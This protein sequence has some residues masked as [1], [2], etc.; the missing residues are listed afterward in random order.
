MFNNFAFSWF[1]TTLCGMK[2]PV[3]GVPHV[4]ILMNRTV[5]TCHLSL[6][7]KILRLNAQILVIPKKGFILTPLSQDHL[8]LPS[9]SVGY[10]MSSAWW[11]CNDWLVCGLT[12]QGQRSSTLL[13]SVHP[14]KTV[15]NNKKCFV[16]YC[17]DCVAIVQSLFSTL[18]NM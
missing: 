7:S 8:M 13:P 6:L 14:V 11:Q 9:H 3:P 5:D 12:G 16:K 10:E 2:C 18:R 4:N 15:I 17:L 1:L